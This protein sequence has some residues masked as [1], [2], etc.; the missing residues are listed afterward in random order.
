MDSERFKRPEPERDQPIRNWSTIYGPYEGSPRAEGEH[1]EH[2][3]VRR[4]VNLGYE[5]VEEYLRQ[6]ERAARGFSAGRVS[7]EA[8]AGEIQG[9][10]SR[11]MQFA[12]DFMSMW[13]ELMGALTMSGVG[14]AGGTSPVFRDW[15]VGATGGPPPFGMGGPGARP[16]SESPQGYGP[17]GFRSGAGAPHHGRVDADAPGPGAHVPGALPAVALETSSF[18]PVEVVVDIR[19]SAMGRRLLAHDLRAPEADKP[20]L[21]DVEIEAL[22]EDGRIHVRIRVPEGHPPGTYSGLVLDE[23]ESTPQGTLCVRVLPLGASSADR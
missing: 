5:V 23:A 2:D 7:P 22:A 11:T 16:G 20:R 14:S 17:P 13:F 12:W 21:R 1:G 9:L 18:G 19:P 6:G 8:W 15:R 3:P 4:G 10:T